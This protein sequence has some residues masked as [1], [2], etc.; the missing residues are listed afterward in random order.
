MHN[1]PDTK[2][3]VW[4]IDKLEDRF[5]VIVDGKGWVLGVDATGVHVRY[6]VNVRGKCFATSHSR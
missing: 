2:P 6:S 4:F 3:D 1:L 5:R